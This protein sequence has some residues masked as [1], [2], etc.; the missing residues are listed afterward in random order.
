MMLT[1]SLS[2]F[3]GIIFGF[4]NVW[5]IKNTIQGITERKC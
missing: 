2:L 3:S 1:N 4:F 5:I